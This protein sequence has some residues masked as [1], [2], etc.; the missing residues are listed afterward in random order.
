MTNRNI[1]LITGANSGVGLELTKKLL[2]EGWEVIALTRSNFFKDL[3]IKEA[4]QNNQ[5]RTYHANFKDFLE[6]KSTL[7]EIK[8]KEKYIDILFNNAGVSFGE[9]HYTNKGRE[10]HF[11]VNTLIPYI[12]IRELKDLLLKG[13]K[14]TII[15]TSSNSHLFLNKFDL[16]SLI[17]PKSNFKKVTG[18]YALSK[19]ALSL[20]TNELATELIT[21]GI[22]I[23]SVCPGPSKTQLTTGDR[24]PFYLLPFRNFLFSHPSKGASRLYDAALYFSDT[25][26]FINKGK[27]TPFKFKEQASFVLKQMDKIYQEDYINGNS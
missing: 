8:S 12:I 2:I 10:V 27:D 22:K 16:N 5:L 15:N 17:Y 24:I 7:I 20:W 13:K 23:R 6:L 1:A 3:Q 19:L 26:I 21:E 11:E 4:L 18:S 9:Y 14:K 25:G